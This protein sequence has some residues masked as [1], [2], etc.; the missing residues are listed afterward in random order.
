[1]FPTLEFFQVFYLVPAPNFQLMMS[2]RNTGQKEYSCFILKLT[3]VF[4]HLYPLLSRSFPP[5]VAVIPF[6]SFDLNTLFAHLLYLWWG[7]GEARYRMAC[8]VWLLYSKRKTK[9]SVLTPSPHTKEVL[10]GSVYQGVCS[11]C[12]WMG[13]IVDFS[14]CLCVIWFLLTWNDFKMRK[15][16]Y[17]PPYFLYVLILFL[18]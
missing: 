15:I 3:Y 2:E 11:S 17:F 7:V 12:L 5:S 9:I 14:F 8:M 13:W 10:E 1:M 6:F 18:L 4:T 16:G